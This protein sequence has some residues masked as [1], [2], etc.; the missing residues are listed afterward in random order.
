MENA[1]NAWVRQVTFEHFAGSAVAIYE[2]CKRVDGRRLPVARAGFGKR[3]LA[4]QH[5]FHDGPAD[6]VFALLRRTRPPRF[7]RRLLRRRAERVCAM[8]STLCRP[9]TAARLQSWASGTLFDNVR[10]DG[11]GLSLMNRGSDGEGA[12]W[13]AANSVLWQC[14][15]SKISC[16]NPPGAQNWAFGCWGEFEG[17]GIW[18]NSNES[19][20]PDSLFVAQTRRPARFRSRAK[21]KT[22]AALDGRIQQPDRGA[23]GGIDCRIAQAGAATFGLHRRRANA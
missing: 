17:N 6:F 16:E 11:N 20:K 1:A 3:R 22:D 21:N 10:I 14:D 18:R 2:S 8:R 7:F 12:G 5:L 19:V 13:S 9:A 4:A 15:A 23:G